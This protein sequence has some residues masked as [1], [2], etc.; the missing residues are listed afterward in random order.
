MNLSVLVAQFPVT[1]DIQKN[2]DE[3][4]KILKKTKQNDLVVFPEGSLSGYDTDLSFL[5]NIDNSQ[6]VNAI[7]LLKDEAVNR[8][9]HLWVGTC[10]FEEGKWYNTAFGFSPLGNV[11]RYNKVNLATHERDIFTYGSELEPFALKFENEII[12]V[13]V[14]LCRDLKYPEQ[15]KWL[16]LRDTHIFLH[17]INAKGDSK[18]QPIW[19]SQLISRATENQ[20]FII[21]VNT[22]AQKQKCPTVVINP[23]GKILHEVISEKTNAFHVDIDLD[24]ISN[25]YLE[26]SRTDL[27]DIN[28]KNTS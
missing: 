10:L 18:E 9:I 2:L 3:M 7:D 1:F 14:Q 16:A 19:K 15:W 5:D 25:W 4:L 11:Y 26:Q 21:S 28:Y 17:L 20:R 22:A 24:L 27:I 6:V 8:K 12:N 23:K 13:G